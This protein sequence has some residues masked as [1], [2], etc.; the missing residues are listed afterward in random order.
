MSF[1]M[2]TFLTKNNNIS[3]FKKS[4]LVKNNECLRELGSREPGLGMW[5][6]K[7]WSSNILPQ[8]LQ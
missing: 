3:Q 8:E 2:K 7:Q 6:R 1:V 4:N 5:Q